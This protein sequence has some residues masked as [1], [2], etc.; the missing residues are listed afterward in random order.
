ME[1]FQTWIRLHPESTDETMVTSVQ[2]RVHDPLWLLGRQWQL[3]ELRH[4][5][6][7]TPVDV[8]IEGASSPL[9]KLRGGLAPPTAA[10]SNPINTTET[11][12]ETLVEREA[13]SERASENL[14]LRTESGMHLIR[15]LRA[16]S[17]QHRVAFW[18]NESPFALPGDDA[19]E[20][21][22]EWFDV[23]NGRV[24]DGALLPVAIRARLAPGGSTPPIDAAEARVLRSWLSWAASRFDQAPRG[25]STWDPEHMEY[26]FAAAGIGAT[27][28]AVVTAPE[29]LEG[30]LEWYD[31]EEGT[32]TLG[33]TGQA[34]PRRAFRVPAPLDFAG[35][36]NPRFW[37]FEDPGVRFDALEML[38]NPAAPPSPATLMVLDFALSYSDDWFL[39]PLTLDAWTIFEATAVAVTDVF[40]DTTIAQPPDGRWNMYR[41]DTA[42]APPRLSRLFLVASPAEANNGP[43]LEE[44]HLL[45]DEVANVAWAVERTT[46]HPLGVAKEPPL[47]PTSV[48][49]ATPPGLRWT[50]TPPPPPGNWFPLLPVAIGRL[51]RGVLWNARTQKPAGRL[52]TEL[53]APRQL[54][55]EEVPPEGAQVVRRWQSARGIDGS[56][57]FWIGRNKTPRQTDIAPAVRFDVVEWK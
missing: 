3:G 42:D 38:S 14:R 21:T 39:I 2:A 50:L 13:V 54:H 25:P 40:G 7:A 53:S 51:A 27:S 16:A 15:L 37:T 1:T 18:V 44:I 36:P 49:A 43:S 55:Q 32:G 20:E 30:Q 22:H 10:G 33:A 24:P 45:R 34:T 52:L 9:T 23:V 17:L 26:G 31:F 48:G 5:A 8:R 35:M 29:Y 19:D 4:D 6:G 28:E 12:L 47:Q 46:P 57:H 56:L 11:P 41:L